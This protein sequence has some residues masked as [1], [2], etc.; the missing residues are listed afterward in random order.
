MLELT[1]ERVGSYERENIIYFNVGRDDQL[2]IVSVHDHKII[3][4]YERKLSF[5]QKRV[6]RLF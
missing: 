1:A 2:F 4:E 3:L 5:N 6:M